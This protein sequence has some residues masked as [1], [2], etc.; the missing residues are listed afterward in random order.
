[1]KKTKTKKTPKKKRGGKR[2]KRMTLG[3]RKRH[4]SITI[5]AMMGDAYPS[6]AMALGQWLMEMGHMI[7]LSEAMSPEPMIEQAMTGIQQ[8][9]LS[10]VDR[11]IPPDKLN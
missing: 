2:P 1:M 7:V 10:S 11:D 5:D 8:T 9:D 6:E 3:G 4:L